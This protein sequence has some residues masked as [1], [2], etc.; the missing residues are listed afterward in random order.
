M[1]RKCRTHYARAID[2]DE[3]DVG[4]EKTDISSD[5]P[6]DS[7][8][9]SEETD[10]D[11]SVYIEDEDHNSASDLECTDS[12][13]QFTAVFLISSPI[14]C[15]VDDSDENTLPKRKKMKTTKAADV[16]PQ[17]LKKDVFSATPLNVMYEVS[18]FTWIHTSPHRAFLLVFRTPSPSRPSTSCADQ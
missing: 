17:S 15:L 14:S 4:Y 18:D 6:T 10:V 8:V 1:C 11:G 9:D 12:F 13:H 7:D 3:T 16:F 2:Y 5:E